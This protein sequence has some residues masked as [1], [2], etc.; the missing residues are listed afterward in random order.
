MRRKAV[1]ALSSGVRNYSPALEIL[2]Q[3]LPEKLRPSKAIDAGV[4]EEVDTVIDA[5]KEAGKRES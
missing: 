3:E 2:A 1:Y 4:M 5:L